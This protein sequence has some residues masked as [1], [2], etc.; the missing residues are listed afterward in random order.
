MNT[1]LQ[2]AFPKAQKPQQTYSLAMT[3][4]SAAL[5]PTVLPT[6]HGT[7]FSNRKHSFSLA[8]MSAITY[9]LH[10]YF[11]HIFY[12]LIMTLSILHN[13]EYENDEDIWQS[14]LLIFE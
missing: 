14:F 11:F 4:E 13:G 6:P 5:T 8:S 2:K 3:S 9:Y 10:F 1:V 7:R 12:F